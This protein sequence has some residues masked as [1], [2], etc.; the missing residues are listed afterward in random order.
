MSKLLIAFV[1]HDDAE[2]VADALRGAG[3]RFTHMPTVGGFL[4]SPNDTFV[5]GVEDAA[6]AD[7][8]R[9]FTE[10]CRGR[11]VEI[12]LVLTERLADWKARTVAHGGATI[13]VADLDRIIRI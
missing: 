9:V 8:V 12:P 5:F 6:E 7:I 3:H 10:V 11:E 13:L 4:G 2:P 1:H